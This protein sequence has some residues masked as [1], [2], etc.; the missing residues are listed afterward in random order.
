MNI[1][2]PLLKQTL[3]YNCLSCCSYVQVVLFRCFVSLS[4]EWEEKTREIRRC[5]CSPLRYPNHHL[6][7]YLQG[8]GIDHHMAKL[9]WA[10]STLCTGLW[11][12][13]AQH[14]AQ[15]TFQAEFST[16]YTGL[17]A[18]D[19]VHFTLYMTRHTALCAH[20]FACRILCTALFAQ[21]FARRI[22]CTALC[23]Q[24]FARRILSMQDS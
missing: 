11:G 15:K 13:C 17:C 1:A 8:A 7:V 19:P 16:L 3:I 14:F 12:F 2:P 10:H 21:D 5:S 9:E 24:D 23:A 18:Q 6:W 4:N 22:L 20:Y